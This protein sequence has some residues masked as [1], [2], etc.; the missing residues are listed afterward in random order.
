MLAFRPVI[1]R[2]LLALFTTVPVPNAKPVGPYSR[3]VLAWLAP[4]VQLKLADV[5]VRLPAARAVGAAHTSGAAVVVKL[6]GPTRALVPVLL[7]VWV[8]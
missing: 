7:Q 4:L 8:T 3:R 1:T 5:A 2:G 6:A